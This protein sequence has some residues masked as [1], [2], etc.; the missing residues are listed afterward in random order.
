M[1]GKIRPETEV[2]FTLTMYI[3]PLSS[4]DSLMIDK[5]TALAE[6]FLTYMALIRFL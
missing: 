4:V 1:L 6:S 2:S 3:G 5:A